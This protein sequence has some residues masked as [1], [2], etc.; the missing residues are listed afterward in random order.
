MKT[1]AHYEV[2]EIK[3]PKWIAAQ[4]AKKRDRANETFHSDSAK[5]LGDELHALAS[6]V[7]S[8]RVFKNYRE[9]FIAV[10][11]ETPRISDYQLIKTLEDFCTANNI[12]RVATKTSVIYRIK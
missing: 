1:A 3:V 6:S 10:K 9:R 2:D 4:D 5:Q 12:E 11:V 7:Y 8:S